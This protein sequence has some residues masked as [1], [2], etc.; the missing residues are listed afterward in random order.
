MLVTL[1]SLRDASSCRITGE[2]S[3]C[4]AIPGTFWDYSRLEGPEGMMVMTMCSM[5]DLV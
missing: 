1:G 5:C 2:L 3:C 4:K